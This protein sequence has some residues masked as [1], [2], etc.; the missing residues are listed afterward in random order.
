MLCCAVLVPLPPGVVQW[1]Y[2]GTYPP[3]SVPTYRLGT[4]LVLGLCNR[5]AV[6]SRQTKTRRMMCSDG[7]EPAIH[8]HGPSHLPPSCLSV[9]LYVRPS[10]KRQ[11]SSSTAGWSRSNGGGGGGGGRLRHYLPTVADPHEERFP[12]R[13]ACRRER[14]RD[15]RRASSFLCSAGRRQPVAEP[16]SRDPQECRWRRHNPWFSGPDRWEGE[17]LMCVCVDGFTFFFFSKVQGKEAEAGGRTGGCSV[18]FSV[19]LLSYFGTEF[20][21]TKLVMIVHVDVAIGVIA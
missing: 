4:L 17:G 1:M 5:G 20:G 7:P 6:E 15:R 9:I 18:F 3:C 10:V 14:E 16:P 19:L 21:G 12:R 11:K 2:P 13:V 8:V